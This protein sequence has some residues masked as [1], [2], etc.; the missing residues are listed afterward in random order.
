M[1]ERENHEKSNIPLPLSDLAAMQEEAGQR[2]TENDRAAV[3]LLAAGITC[4]LGAAATDWTYYGLSYLGILLL[5]G[6]GI[7][8]AFEEPKNR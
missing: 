3:Y 7:S 8:W 6:A 5:V 2:E 1:D 4:F